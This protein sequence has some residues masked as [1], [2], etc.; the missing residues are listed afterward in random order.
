LGGNGGIAPEAA[1]ATDGPVVGGKTIDGCGGIA[2]DHGIALCGP[3]SG[4]K[5]G[6]GSGSAGCDVVTL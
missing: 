3:N 1:V 6:G 5:E 2:P 4:E